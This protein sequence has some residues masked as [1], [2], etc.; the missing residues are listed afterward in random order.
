MV[1]QCKG[2]EFCLN[3]DVPEIEFEKITFS[4]PFPI[5]KRDRL[6]E[7]AKRELRKM[8]WKTMIT[9]PV[10][11]QLPAMIYFNP[12]RGRGKLPEKG[13][14]GILMEF[15]L[16]ELTKKP[17]FDGI[18]FVGKDQKN[19]PSFMMGFQE[20]WEWALDVKN[21]LPSMRYSGL[22]RALA[23]LCTQGGLYE[24]DFIRSDGYF[25]GAKS[26]S[27][28]EFN[29]TIE[30][31]VQREIPIFNYIIPLKAHEKPLKP[32]NRSKK[33]KTTDDKDIDKLAD[34]LDAGLLLN[35]SLF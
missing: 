31:A 30:Q 13:L 22:P 23:D 18:V 33:R 28:S 26:W 15:N 5:P 24:M 32:L 19:P 34:S 14:W 7:E 27:F 16:M 6:T 4:T 29:I 9:T 35:W 10:S 2:C 12:Q 25:Q 3:P 20:M 21:V 17:R 1:S 11:I 8:D